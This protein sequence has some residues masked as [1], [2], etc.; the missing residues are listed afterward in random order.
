MAQAGFELTESSV[1]LP[2]ATQVVMT[3]LLVPS[4]WPSSVLR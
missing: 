1:P 3:L 2:S 4:P